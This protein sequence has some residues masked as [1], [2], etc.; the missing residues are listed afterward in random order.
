MFHVAGGS[1]VG[2]GLELDAERAVAEH[3][4][5]SRKFH[6]GEQPGLAARAASSSKSCLTIAKSYK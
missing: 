2:V 1:G 5:Y 6:A 3:K 4:V